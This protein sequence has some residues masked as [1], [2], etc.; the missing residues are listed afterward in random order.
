MKTELIEKIE[1][2]IQGHLSYAELS[3]FAAFENVDDLD[4]KIE[5]LKNIKTAV[6]VDGLRTQLQQLLS[7]DKKTERSKSR[8]I[9]MKPARWAIGIAASVL[10]VVVGYWSMMQHNGKNSDWKNFSFIDPGLP[11]TMSQTDNYALYDAL[12]Y[13]GEENYKTTIEKLEELQLLGITSDTISYYL[14]AS[15]YYNGEYQQAASTLLEIAD[16]ES[17]Y[18]Q[19]RAQWLL[20]FCDLE[21][22]QFSEAKIKL[23][24][25]LNDADHMFYEKAEKLNKTLQ[26]K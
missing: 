26:S 9:I 6:G 22:E 19:D 1:E 15:Q 4:E 8:T 10:I 16:N 21:R 14:G 18:F 3:A 7:E 11:V 20:V 13:Y 24:T 17:S 12:T 2:Y 5:W 25:I 23:Q